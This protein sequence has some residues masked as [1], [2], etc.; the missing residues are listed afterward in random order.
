[1]SLRF[2][3]VTR[4]A[5]AALLLGAI[6]PRGATASPV[7]TIHPGG[8]P[9]SPDTVV[10]D[11]AVRRAPSLLALRAAGP[12]GADT[13]PAGADS[14][15][16]PRPIPAAGATA[17][18]AAPLDPPGEGITF[19]G[20]KSVSVEVGN[21][22][23]A[24]LG[25][26]LDLTVRGKVAGDVEVA[27][28]VSD[29]QLPFE[30]DG[31]SRELDD[32]DRLSLSIRSS[33]AEATMGDFFLDGLPGQFAR[34][35]RHLEGVRG[36]ARAGGARWN[37]AA[38]NAKGEKRTVEFHGEE[39]RQGPYALTSRSLS[40]DVGGIVAGSEVIWLDGARLK[41]GADDDYVMDYGAGTVTFTVRHPITPQSRI[42]I[43]FE[44]AA[45]RYRRS[46]Y[47]ATTQGGR[48]GAGS[49]YASYVTEGDDSKRPV[50]AELTPDDR[51]ALSQM[52]DSASTALP[53]GVRY[54][55]PG[56]GSYAWDVTDP[57][58]PHWVYLGPSRGDY[59][60]EFAGVGPGR[61]EYADTVA[62]DGSRFYRFRGENLGS[63]VPGRSVAVPSSKKLLD[64]GGAARLFG[65]LALEGEAARSGFDENALSSR[66]DG[67]NLGTAARLAARLDPRRIALGGLNLG[68][69]QVQ[70]A[71]RSTGERF[72]PFDRINPAFEG[73]RWNQASGSVGE[74]RQE[75]SLQYDPATALGVHGEI[76]RRA[77]SGGSRSTRRA[78]GMN[79]RTAVVGAVH[80]E[81]ARNTGALE[82]GLRSLLGV[83][84]SREKGIVM[85]RVS[86]REE[87]I[88]GQEGDSADERSSREVQL[89]LKLAP[90]ASVRLRGGYGV[91]DGEILYR[92]GGPRIEDRATTWDGG[93]SARSG[94]SLSIDGG[95]T[96]RRVASTA[97]PQGT[98]LAQLAVL[99]GRP[100]APVTSELRFDVTQLREPVQIRQLRAV[101]AGGGSYDQFG[102]PTLGGGY[103]LVATTGDPSTRSRAVAQWRLD[104]YP[105]RAPVG[106]GKKRPLWR[107]FGGSS[108]IRLETLST[109]PLGRLE[110]ALDPADYLAVGTTLRGNV[111]ARQT[112]EYTPPSG[113]SD[114]R[115]EAGF[116]RER[117]GEI[118]LLASQR[119]A[120]DAKVSVRHPLPLQLRAAATAA[121]DRSLQSV[122]RDDTGEELRSALRGRAFELE[123]SRQLQRDWSVSILSRQRR[124]ID[125][126]H[127]GYFD[128]WSVGPT[129]RYS[130]GARFRLDGRTL[131]GWSDQ[132][133]GYSPPGLYFGTPAGSRLDYD[134]LGECRMRDNV[135]ISLSWSGF[136]APARPAYYTGRFELRG[137]F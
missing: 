90:S 20:L 38:A 8:V 80:W 71:L 40:A 3:L 101:S 77:V 119:D 130:S 129:A 87:R 1:V 10:V 118:E 82:Q 23:T 24:S 115:A 107:G 14:V 17:L 42:A 54:S 56:Q 126:T 22:R 123:V 41:R 64:L 15:V 74:D 104:T 49:W 86:A 83:D 51:A 137:T 28:M 93:L 34:L 124:D 113:R 59:E 70:S 27:A 55:G 35:T 44:A 29:R 128:L 81:E 33:R 95:F 21:N 132:Q 133:G 61:G 103:E 106:A 63:Y 100:G 102:N 68:T 2:R 105:G 91:R 84:L 108:F 7:P 13:A 109:L 57:A 36:T 5:A 16:R 37:V 134:F 96:R 116:R 6:A 45:S 76:G 98:D 125:M 79:L 72:A 69:I 43:D 131:W 85:P 62:A 112:L 122:R 52:G 136:K 114:A 66:D 67:D 92:A 117:V 32:L 26:T 127:G 99:A 12:L 111:N 78:A 48:E 75:L 30:P 60:V 97:G 46:L 53:S 4:A 135:S 39:G 9:D 94:T 19:S 120:W 121:Y 50:G 25:Q 18:A 110:H 31:S 11:F 88:R 73:D 47:A 58:S 65:A 89:G